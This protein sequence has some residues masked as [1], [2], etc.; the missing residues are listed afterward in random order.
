M[1]HDGRMPTTLNK[2]FADNIYTFYTL[3]PHS[4]ISLNGREE[5]KEVNQ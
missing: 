3:F 4:I 5:G 2:G 1:L